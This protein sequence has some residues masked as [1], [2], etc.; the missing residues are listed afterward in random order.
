MTGDTQKPLVRRIRCSTWIVALLAACVMVVVE[1]PGRRTGATTYSHGWPLAYLERDYRPD[2]AANPF[3][4]NVL[5]APS[6]LADVSNEKRLLEH[7]AE[8]DD[9]EYQTINEVWA[10]SGLC[11]S[12]ERG[13]KLN[14]WSYVNVKRRALFWI[15]PDVCAALALVIAA[16]V[17]WQWLRVRMRLAGRSRPGDGQAVDNDRSRRLYRHHRN[18]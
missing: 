1:I 9:R 16:A 4:F 12:A 5:V 18:N 17:V 3:L 2:T 6:S 13:E 15:V 14:P 8:T 10:V 11:V 7:S